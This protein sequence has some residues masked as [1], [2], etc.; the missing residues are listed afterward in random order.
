MLHLTRLTTA[1]FMI[2]LACYLFIPAVG[3]A[4]SK[5]AYA[6]VNSFAQPLG[7]NVSN[8]V[9]SDC[10]GLSSSESEVTTATSTTAAAT[11][12]GNVPSTVRT[13]TVP[14]IGAMPSAAILHMELVFK[15]RNQG[16]FTKCLAEINDPSSPE[17]R[18][19]LNANS[20]APFV[21][22]PSQKASAQN[23]LEAHGLTVTDGPSP[24]VLDVIGSAGLVQSLFQLHMRLYETVSGHV[25]YSADADPTL[26]QDLASGVEGLTGLQNYTVVKPAEQP[27]TCSGPYCAQAVEVGY[28]MAGLY[29]SGFNGAGVTVAVV[30]GPGDPN[31]SSALHQYDLQYNLQDP[32]FQ[33]QCGG[34]STWGPCSTVSYDPTWASEAAMDIEAVHAMAPGAAID[35]FYATSSP[36]GTD[37]FIDAIDYVASNHI[38][39]I[40]SDSWTYAC[41]PGAHSCSDAEFQLQNPSFVSE[42]DSRFEMD[43]AQGLTI[44]F[45]TGDQ[46][47]TPDG[48][49]LGVEFPASDPNVLAVGAT[50][51]TLVG[52]G[53]NTC[54]GYGSEDGALISGGGYSGVFAEPSW[55]TAAIGSTPSGFGGHG[56]GVPDVSM[57]GYTPG[58]WVYST[59]SDECGTIS[60]Q[61]GWF[62]CA[63]TSLSTPL[64]AGFLA[65]AVQLNGG[66]GFG[67]IDPLIYKFASSGKYP[68]DFHDITSGSNNG[69]DAEVGWDPVTGWGSPVGSNLAL[70]LGPARFTVTNSGGIIVDQGFSNS[71]RINV[72]LTSGSPLPTGLACVSGL[73]AR[74]SCSF[75]QLTATPNYTS[76][77]TIN[78]EPSTPVGFYSVT[79][80][81]TT[82]LATNSTTLSLTV[83]QSQRS[84]TLTSLPQIYN[85]PLTFVSGWNLI[86]LPV[87]PAANSTFPNSVD[88]IFGSNGT[89]GFMGNVTSVYT[90]AGGVWRYCA[91]AKLGSGAGTKYTCNGTLKN[92]VDGKGYWVYAE[93]AF[94]L[95]N[96]N[97]LAP[98][99]GGLVGSVILPSSPPPSYSLTVGWNLAG[100]KPQ[101]NPTASETVST[102]LSSI[103]GDYNVNSL[104]IYGNPT[105]T[106]V[107]A[108][109]ATMIAPGEAMWIYVTSHAGATLRP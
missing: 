88:G 92:M 43:A 5:V 35:L 89:Y 86:S 47:A 94:T 68:S 65:P 49:N 76:T 96:A 53:T 104:W 1:A 107:R 3:A 85:C 79:V 38:A 61:A 46:G 16:Q 14:E 54:T 70:D 4:L 11:V 101:P 12:P 62:Y 91:V 13:N 87:V 7:N 45:A 73:P 72:N 66:V 74:A 37:P 26:P 67:N 6:P 32:N 10:S 59:D 8:T 31:P 33:V 102:Y 50:D 55:Q 34:G 18:H 106:W 57:L 51:L 82:K 28:S 40:V 109:D 9:T 29:S 80:N 30:D 84:C 77:L 42:V 22:T 17:Y 27:T 60:P 58:F 95:N 39:Q 52:C 69:Y 103:N 19:F 71:T 44:V 97:N 21:E 48:S 99:W 36:S 41:E 64:W 83:N 81:G 108:T 20:L 23:F 15:I 24:L 25:F 100:Y 78:T 75:S 93:A 2:L 56:R 90:Y 63:G 105:G 98:T